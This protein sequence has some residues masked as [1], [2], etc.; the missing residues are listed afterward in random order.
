LEDQ[1]ITDELDEIRRDMG[2][3]LDDKPKKKKK[4]KRS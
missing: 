4:S 3:D 2:L 1:R